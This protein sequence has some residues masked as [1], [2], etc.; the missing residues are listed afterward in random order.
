MSMRSSRKAFV[1]NFRQKDKMLP[2]LDLELMR[3][4]AQMTVIENDTKTSI[5]HTVD[6][7]TCSRKVQGG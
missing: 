4:V 7:T 2:F 6:V 3:E 5:V 1:T